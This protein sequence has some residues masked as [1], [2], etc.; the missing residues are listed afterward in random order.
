MQFTDFYSAVA[1]ALRLR[2]NGCQVYGVRDDVDVWQL[3]YAVA[4]CIQGQRPGGADDPVWQ[5]LTEKEEEEE[6]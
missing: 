5:V 1:E 3:E 2:A 4:T 6:E